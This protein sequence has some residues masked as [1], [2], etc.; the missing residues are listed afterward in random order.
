M[1]D[2]IKTIVSN[3]GLT[4]Q[5]VKQVVDEVVKFLKEKLPA[6][7]AGQVDVLLGNLDTNKDGSVA[8]EIKTVLGGA[9]GGLLGGDKK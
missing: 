3:T 2:L 5:A 9:L 1:E 8:D 6:P 4:E 7:L